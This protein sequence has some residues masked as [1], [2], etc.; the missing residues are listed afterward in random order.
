[1]EEGQDLEGELVLGV[2][3]SDDSDEEEVPTPP[4]P[5]RSIPD[6]KSRNRY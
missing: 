5:R 1:M 3:Q 6:Y 4:E 2:K